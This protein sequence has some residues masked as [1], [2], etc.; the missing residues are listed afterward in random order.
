M[1]ASGKKRVQLTITD[2]LLADIE[3]LAAASGCKQSQVACMLIALGLERVADISSGSGGS[4]SGG[5]GSGDGSGSGGSG[6]GDG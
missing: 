2:E 3:R 6:S 5:S 4:G 1:V